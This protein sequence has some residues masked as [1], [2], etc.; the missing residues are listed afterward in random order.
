MK[1]CFLWICLAS[2]FFADIRRK[3]SVSGCSIYAKGFWCSHSKLSK[4]SIQAD[5]PSSQCY[6][7]CMLLI[8]HLSFCHI[9]M[10]RPFATALCVFAWC[11][12][13]YRL[14]LRRMKFMLRWQSSQSTLWVL[15]H[16]FV[17]FCTHNLLVSS[18]FFFFPLLELQNSPLRKFN[19]L[20]P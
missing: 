3:Y 18:K 10:N 4:S 6:S 2:V 7:P 16:F 8:F 11:W 1:I 13:F 20:C 5:L 17:L 19:P 15:W 9:Q 12:L 14:M